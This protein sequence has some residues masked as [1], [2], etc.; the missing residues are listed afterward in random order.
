M[1]NPILQTLESL[2][3]QLPSVYVLIADGLFLLVFVSIAKWLSRYIVVYM[4]FVLPGTLAHELAHWGVAVITNGKPTFPSL[5]F[6][7]TRDGVMLGQVVFKNPRWY[8]AALIALAPLLL[9]PLVV[10]L[11]IHAAARIPLLHARH[12]ISLY[13]IITAGFSALPSAVDVRVAWK[14]SAPVLLATVVLAL[15][16]LFFRYNNL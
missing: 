5:S 13:L 15:T 2:V 11:Y 6:K 9:L 14:Y 1:T 7:H 16:L 10:W 3:R 12:W 4:L 8:N